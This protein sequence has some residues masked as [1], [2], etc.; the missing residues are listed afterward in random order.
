M[1]AE[2]AGHGTPVSEQRSRRP[3]SAIVDIDGTLVDSN[4]QHALAWYRALREFDVTRE[5]WRLHRL[6]GMGGDHL[7]EEIA[8]ADV[9]AAHGDAIREAEQERFRELID[10]V[11]A[12]PRAAALVRVLGERGRPVVLA[13]SAQAWQ[14]EHYLDLVGVRDDITGWTSADD[15]DRTKPDPDL[16][17]AARAK[18]GAG[19][20]VMIGDS[21][22]D[23]AA[24][25]RAGIEAVAVLT[26]GFSR[27]ELT[28]A[29]AAAVFSSLG[30][31]IDHLDET[32]LAGA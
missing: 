32:P 7:V 4:Y 21:T 13:S 27:E 29:G 31:L 2:A 23:C 6:I 28:D 30:E 9:E 3:P 15:V 12:L 17:A 14:V 18:A 19:R 8:G 16:V 10:E 20:A 5:L 25:R 22:W 24:A 1:A 26:G 11:A